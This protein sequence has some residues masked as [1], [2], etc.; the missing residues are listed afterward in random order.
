L[1]QRSGHNQILFSDIS[2]KSVWKHLERVIRQ[3]YLLNDVFNDWLE[4][5]LNTYLSFTDNFRRPNF[6]EKFKQQK[7][8]APYEDAYMTIVRRYADRDKNK[9]KGER[10]LDHFEGNGSTATR[11]C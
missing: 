11:F 8:D 9:Q 7:L 5:M 10:A 2:G 1:S 4:L 3:G 6:E